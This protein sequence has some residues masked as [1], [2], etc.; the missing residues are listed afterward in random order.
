MVKGSDL[1]VDFFVFFFCF[2]LFVACEEL[3]LGRNLGFTQGFE[4]WMMAKERVSLRMIEAL[5]W[6]R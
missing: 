3:G 5:S 6:A 1:V 4:I 2:C